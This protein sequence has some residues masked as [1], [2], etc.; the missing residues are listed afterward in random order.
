MTYGALKTRIA[1]EI[2][3]S[4]LS[5]QIILA[6]ET[7]IKFYER[8]EFYFNAKTGT[9]VTVAA[10]EYYGSAANTDIPNI[11]R[12]LDPMKATSSGYKY[13]IGI[14]PFSEIDTAQDGNRTGRPEDAAY[15]AEQ[16]R[17]YPIPD[18]VYT[19]TMAYIYRLPALVEDANENAWT[20]DAEELIR[21][22]AKMIIAAD[23]LRDV[24]MYNAAKEFEKDAYK[25]LREET[26][27]RR[28]VSR[29]RTDIPAST[30]Y[31]IYVDQ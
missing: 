12:I 10:Q 19:V 2:A 8:K 9:F 15:F 13:D 26:R 30:R 17:L 5:S 14:V 6:I 3:D 22:R 4:T 28:S 16:L 21:Q 23:V 29:L 24:D 7:A 11:I 18:A 1:D 20:E 27:S 25:A 31:N